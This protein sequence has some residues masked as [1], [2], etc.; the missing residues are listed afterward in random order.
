MSGR[1]AAHI[2]TRRRETQAGR[3]A[4]PVSEISV[5]AQNAGGQPGPLL[6]QRAHSWGET[7]GVT[8]RLQHQRELL[9]AIPAL[10]WVWVS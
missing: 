4:D 3:Q 5:K 8:R 10:D 2:T 1:G 7:L 6:L 9:Q